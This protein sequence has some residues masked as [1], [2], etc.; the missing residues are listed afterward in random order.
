MSE[1]VYRIL[2]VVLMAVSLACYW[3]NEKDAA[4]FGIVMALAVHLI[5]IEYRLDR[6]GDA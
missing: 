4:L 3:A 2:Y 1:L 6:G 5:S